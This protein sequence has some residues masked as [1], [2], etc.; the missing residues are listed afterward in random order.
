MQIFSQ[1]CDK[2]Y[3]YRGG[4]GDIIALEVQKHS[5]S[6]KVIQI[7]VFMLFIYVFC[8]CKWNVLYLQK[9][10]TEQRNKKKT[11]E[12]RFP[13][14]VSYIWARFFEHGRYKKT[15]QLLYLTIDAGKTVL[16][17]KLSTDSSWRKFGIYVINILFH[18][19]N[20]FAYNFAHDWMRWEVG[21][22]SY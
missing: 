20:I 16:I 14:H 17:F 4:G 11:N 6:R 19:N 12:M 18:W 1:T 9:K 3:L 2:Q 8:Q 15:N 21:Y 13:H 7:I 22:Y 5:D 10:T